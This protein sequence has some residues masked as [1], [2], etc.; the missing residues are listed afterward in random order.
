MS[1]ITISCFAPKPPPRRGFMTRM[2]LTGRPEK[3]RHHPAHVE[4]DLG[5]GAQHQ[6][7]VLVEPPDGDVGLDGRVLDL[8][9]VEGL[10]EDAVRAG[11]RRLQ[12]PRRRRSVPRCGD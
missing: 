9:D 1:S 6:P 12:S 5:G 2:R 3:R 11:E 8:L 4:R 10:L 7:L